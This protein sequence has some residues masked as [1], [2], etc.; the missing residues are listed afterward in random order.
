MSRLTQDGTA[1]PVSGGQILR[2]ER[3]QENSNFPSSA[4]HKQDW[5]PYPV[6]LYSAICDIHT[7]HQSTMKS[8]IDKI[9]P[10][11]KPVR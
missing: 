7:Y 1:E 6:N 2:C 5:Q 10:G 3:G 9:I 11:R 8:Q 4:D